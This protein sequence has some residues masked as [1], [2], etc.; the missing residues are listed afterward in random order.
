MPSLKRKLAK[1]AERLSGAMIVHPAEA[2]YLPER[3][4]LKRFF[5]HFAVDAVFDVGANEG[6]Y[7]TRLRRDV[8]YSGPILSFEPIP[9]VA[10][11][12]A[13][14]A[15]DDPLWFV[16][17]VAL[18]R[19]AGAATFHVMADSVFSSLHRP[20]GDQPQMLVA[21]NAVAREIQV[22]RSTLAAELPAW[23][24]RLGFSRPFLKMDTQG[25]DLAVVRG[26]GPAIASFVGLQSELSVRRLYE[27]TSSFAEVL[28]VYEELGFRPSALAP[29]VDAH[30][31]DLLEVDCIMYRADLA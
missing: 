25:N 14:R 26:A 27:G 16:A 22:M 15:A 17:P 10:E 28:E 20:A 31:P 7:A 5:D 12:L 21:Q 23:R 4:H 8:G 2:C 24:D 1:V 11:A 13:A 19:E 18:D 9:E 6:Q 30:F 3:L 29:S